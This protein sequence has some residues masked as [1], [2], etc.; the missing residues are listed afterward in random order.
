MTISSIAIV[1][2]ELDIQ[3][4]LAGHLAECCQTIFFASGVDETRIILRNGQLSAI[5]CSQKLPDGSFVDIVAL[6]K[7]VVHKVPVIVFSPFADWAEYLKIVGAGAFDYIRYPPTRGE[8]ERVV[9]NALS[10]YPEAAFDDASA[11]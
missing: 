9:R 1:S 11:A 2:P 10:R 7:G 6:N 8:I 4:G 3:N 5:V